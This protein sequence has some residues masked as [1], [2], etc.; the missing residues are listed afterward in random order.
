MNYLLKMKLFGLLSESS[1]VTNEE[2]QNA[3]GC[4]MDQVKATVVQSEQSCSEIFRML[5]VT[6]IELVCMESQYRY[7]Q[8]KKCSEKP[9]FAESYLVSRI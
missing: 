3:Y 5:N 9:V 7:E 8:E 6:R 4:F 2:M 1:Q